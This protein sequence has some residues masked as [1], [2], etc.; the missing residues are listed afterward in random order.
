MQK[1]KI[2][3]VKIVCCSKKIKKRDFVLQYRMLNC[4]EIATARAL[5][6]GV[7]KL[8]ELKA[9]WNITE[10][11]QGKGNFNLDKLP[12]KKFLTDGDDIG[13][14]LVP[15]TKSKVCWEKYYSTPVKKKQNPVMDIFIIPNNRNKNDVE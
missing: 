10:S 7:K 12:A 2:P 15:K 6:I 8:K 13:E 5:H 3:A 11:W 1:P 14:P 4:S 9:K